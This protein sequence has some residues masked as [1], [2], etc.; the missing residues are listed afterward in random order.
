MDVDEYV[1]LIYQICVNSI[2][3]SQGICGGDGFELILW[4][5]G[6]V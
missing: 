2:V 4:A 6:A 5:I 3:L 1:R